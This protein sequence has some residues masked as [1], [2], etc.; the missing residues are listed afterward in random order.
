MKHP[1]TARQ[2]IQA[3]PAEGEVARANTPVR[4]DRSPRQTQPIDR[5]ALIASAFEAC[6]R[7]KGLNATSLTDIATASGMTP[8]H[9][10]Y[11]FERKEDIVEFY[12]TRLSE[13]IVAAISKLP[14]RSPDQ[15]LVEFAGYFVGGPEVDRTSIGIMIE[16]FGMTVHDAR[17]SRIKAR[18]D[19]FVR[20]TFTD[21][22][23]W[24]GTAKGI[25]VEEAAYTAWCLEIGMKF[26]AAF[27]LD[28]SRERALAIFLTE[29]RR[30]A[31]LKQ[32]RGTRRSPARSG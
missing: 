25:S 18:F 14:R 32:R 9:L 23:S 26:N 20:R 19:N 7:E 8:S 30:L 29:T 1:K 22:F 21:F 15:W 12:L 10:R 17:L 13:E 28:F 24:A 16:I 31:G 4:A 2:S 3:G 6:I 11:Y 27:Q 5:R